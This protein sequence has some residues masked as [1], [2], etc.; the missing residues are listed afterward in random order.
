MDRIFQP[1]YTT[2]KEGTGLGLSIAEK[3]VKAHGGKIEVESEEGKGTKVKVVLPRKKSSWE[4][5]NGE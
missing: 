5:V 3:I 2:K 4:Q 1:F